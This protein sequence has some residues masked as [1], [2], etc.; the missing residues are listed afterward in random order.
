MT[1]QALILPESREVATIKRKATK[2][3]ERSRAPSTDKA[4]R[5]A[6]AD[7]EEFCQEYRAVALPAQPSSV[8]AYITHLAD[9]QK[10][11]TI[12]LKLA[13]IA[14][15]HRR[16]GH[17]NPGDDERVK[18]IMA[19]IRRTLGTAP[20]KKAP[21]RLDQLRKMIESLPDGL[22]GVR[23]KAIILAGWAGAFRRSEL[24]GLNVSDL[25]FAPDKMSLRVRRSKTDPE[26]QGKTK[27]I[28][29]LDDSQICPVR[30]L[31]AWLKAASIGEGPL[32][33]AIDRWGHVRQ[34]R[35]SDKAVA[36]IVKAAAERAGLDPDLFAGHSLR[37]GFVTAATSGRA[38]SRD[39]MQQTGHTSETTMRGYIQDAGLGAMAAVRAAF[40]EKPA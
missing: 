14:A 28:P 9:G 11:A 29:V 3:A 19:G 12:Q 17:P 16:A 8:A 4:Y 13:A 33:R 40:G 21:V 7:F 32:F 2:Y 15:A 30:A 20:D 38:E 10:V 25:R 27:T 36:L 6:W 24:V 5:A 18:T 23:D 35:L 37:S 39:I 22:A 26:G 34:S 1:K 31:R